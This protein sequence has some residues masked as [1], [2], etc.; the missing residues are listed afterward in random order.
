MARIQKLASPALPFATP[1]YGSAYFDQLLK[2]MR[3]YF[4][5]VDSTVNQLVS[6]PVYTVANLPSAAT[7]GIGARSFVTDATSPTFGATVAGSGSVATPVYS[8]GTN[9][10]VG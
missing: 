6:P 2:V 10:K 1:I 4:T 9:W 8:D 7:M 3:L 5:Q